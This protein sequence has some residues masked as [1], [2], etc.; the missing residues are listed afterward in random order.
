VTSEREIAKT[1][2][3]SEQRWQEIYN[4][5]PQITNPNNI[6]AGTEVRMPADARM[7]NN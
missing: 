1:L 6:P 3:G 5:N 4:L 7:P 2:L